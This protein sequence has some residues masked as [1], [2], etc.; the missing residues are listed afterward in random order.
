MF[1]CWKDWSLE[2]TLPKW[3]RA[4]L[5]WKQRA[6]KIESEPQK[7]EMWSRKGMESIMV[8]QLTWPIT[9]LLCADEAS[10]ANNFKVRQQYICSNLKKESESS[11]WKMTW[12]LEW[13]WRIEAWGRSKCIDLEMEES[14]GSKW[15]DEWSDWMEVKKRNFKNKWILQTLD[16]RIRE[17]KLKDDWSAWM[18]IM[19][20]TSRSEYVKLDIEESE[21]SNW[22][23]KYQ[24]EW[25]W[26]NEERQACMCSESLNCEC[27][28]KKSKTLKWNQKPGS[29]VHNWQED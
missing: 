4:N 27:A 2:L 23:V 22:R 7:E 15:T 24:I 8:A 16:W 5:R 17:F 18:E 21:S 3:R 13:D 28:F 10:S 14:E 9:Q 12:Q 29:K 26:R 1:R 6:S 19:S 20:R 25:K 11:N